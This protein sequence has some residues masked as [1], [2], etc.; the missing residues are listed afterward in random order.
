MKR[1]TW[2]I[3]GIVLALPLGGRAVSLPASVAGPMPVAQNPAA[4]G[5]GPIEGIFTIPATK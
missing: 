4:A 1:K 5:G 2:F 3:R